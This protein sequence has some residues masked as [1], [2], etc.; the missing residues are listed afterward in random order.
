LNAINASHTFF[1]CAISCALSAA[2]SAHPRTPAKN[3]VTAERNKTT[4]VEE[5][6]MAPMNTAET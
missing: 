6:F 1:I 4:K 3:S 2:S 5:R